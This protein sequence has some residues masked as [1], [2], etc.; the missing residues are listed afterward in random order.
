LGELV[1]ASSLEEAILLALRRS[2]GSK[3]EQLAE[4]TGLPRTNF[5]RRLKNRLG[6]PLER[7][8]ARE[9][10]EAEHGRYQLTE[11]GRRTVAER[12]DEIP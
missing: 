1:D 5:G 6:E 8:L 10:I 11:K 9:L 2:P 12:F 3:A 4:A 7:L